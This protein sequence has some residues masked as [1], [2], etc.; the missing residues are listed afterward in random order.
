[1]HSGTS[2]KLFAEA[3]QYLPGGVNS[4]VRA[5]R[6]VGGTP[7][8]IRRGAGSTIV[9][10]D[11][12]AYIDYVGSW[13]PLILGHA[14][15]RVVEAVQEAL[16]EGTTFGAPT[17]RETE[18]AKKITRALPSVERV[19]LVTS[20]TE[21]TMTALR[22]ARAFTGRPKII[23][24]DG[25]YHGHSD[26]L[27]VRAGSG[28]MTFGVPDSP[29]VPEA[30]VS[31]TLVARFN[32]LEELE[33]RFAA[34]GEQIAAVILEP[35]V[36]N[37]GVVR[38]TKGFLEGLVQIARR[39]GTLVI[40]DEVMTGF[41]VAYGGVQTT[42][43]MRPD[44]TC[45]GK[46]IGGGLPLAAVGG[47]RDVMEKLAPEGPVYQAGTLSG[48]PLAVAAGLATLDQLAEPGVY[49]QLESRAAGLE[50]GVREVLS[51]RGQQAC[52]NRVG[53][54]WSLFFDVDQVVDADSA[55]R[56]N[57]DRF[58]TY[59]RGM[60]ERG[61]YLPPS[62]FETAFLSLA[63]TTADIDS[64][65]E[66]VDRVLESAGWRA[67]GWHRPF[68]IWHSAWSRV[69]G[70][71]RRVGIGRSLYGIRCRVRQHHCGCG[72][73]RLLYRHVPRYVTTLHLGADDRRYDRC[74][75][76]PTLV[77]PEVQRRPL[78]SRMPIRLEDIERVHLGLLALTVLLSLITG[79]FSAW[80]VLLGGGVMG[81]NFWLMRQ[82]MRRM[83]T[84]ER[85][86]RPVL[87][88]ALVLAKFSLFIGLLGLLFWR[89]QIDPAG[90]G[91]G[92]TLLLVACVVV[93]VRP[94][95][96]EPA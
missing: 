59:F 95:S 45:L 36:G 7:R 96:H 70:E 85:S 94:R 23:K 30:L 20:G 17:E 3:V 31:Q 84:P 14:N 58:A 53:S 60:L 28:A 24:F 93:A 67:A 44:L 76:A 42:L 83:L 39:S 9:D 16:R 78:I 34:E 5:W 10:V 64:T 41:R 48:N 72:V 68:A 66:A 82:M 91:V 18:L 12:N 56:C 89:V 79:W 4:P 71:G 35:V 80:S 52:M 1:M 22:L 19:R 49:E 32:N 50:T 92:A 77:S 75:T 55:R 29:G 15:E 13:G 87:M 11:G 74:R 43:S 33:R 81:V 61:V 57:A 62:A 40:F 25:C 6:A 86:R 27:L 63:H 69:D 38:P 26:A 51:R 73:G 54:M 90:F 8:F 46:V 37:M 21:A 2:A 88:M 47:R 65:V